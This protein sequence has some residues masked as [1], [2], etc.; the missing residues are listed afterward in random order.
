MNSDISKENLWNILSTEVDRPHVHL[1]NK[2][3]ILEPDFSD[4][5]EIQTFG[6]RKHS[7]NRMDSFFGFWQCLQR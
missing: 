3:N 7:N 1:T 6:F 4:D 5:N 2:L